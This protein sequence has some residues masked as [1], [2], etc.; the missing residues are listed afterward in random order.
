MHASNCHHDNKAERQSTLLTN[1]PREIKIDLRNQLQF[2]LWAEYPPSF[3]P[4]I[5]LSESDCAG[6]RNCKV[7]QKTFEH[8]L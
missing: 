1:N 3:N 4:L 6:G 7:L 5:T 8:C 2:Y